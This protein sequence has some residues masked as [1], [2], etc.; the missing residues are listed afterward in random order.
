MSR[1]DMFDIDRLADAHYASRDPQYA[2]DTYRCCLCGMR[3][4]YDEV[5][6]HDDEPYCVEC[7]EAKGYIE[8]DTDE[9]EH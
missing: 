9:T 4:E 7:A 8:E 6:W 5:L 2:D 3:L 1:I